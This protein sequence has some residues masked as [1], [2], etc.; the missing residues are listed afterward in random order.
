MLF[1]KLLDIHLFRRIQIFDPDLQLHVKAQSI[2]EG[3]LQQGLIIIQHHAPLKIRITPE[4]SLCA[5]QRNGNQGI[6]PEIDCNVRKISFIGT[7]LFDLFKHFRK[8][9]HK[10][11]TSLQALAE[12]ALPIHI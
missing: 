1:F 6:D 7:V 10:I 11:C 4:H 8:G 2:A 3:V 9:I 12:S 5:V